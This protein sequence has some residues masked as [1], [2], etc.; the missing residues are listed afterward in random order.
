[1]L[2]TQLKEFWPHMPACNHHGNQNPEY[3]HLF[4]K[5][6]ESPPAS[7]H[8]CCAFYLCILILPVSELDVNGNREHVLF[9]FAIST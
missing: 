8:H 5:F 3:F 2:N 1:M 7:V 4:G 6:S 9:M